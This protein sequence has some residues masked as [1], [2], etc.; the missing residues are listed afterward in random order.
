VGTVARTARIKLTG[1]STDGVDAYSSLEDQVALTY[2]AAYHYAGA[3]D[4]KPYTHRGVPGRAGPMIMKRITETLF[5]HP[6]KGVRDKINGLVSQVLRK[7]DAA[8]CVVHPAD[9]E[10]MPTWFVADRMPP[11]LTIVALSHA[12]ADKTGT[13]VKPGPSASR[14]VETYAEHKLTPEEAGETMPPG[15]VTVRQTEPKRVLTPEERIAPLKERLEQASREHLELVEEVFRLIAAHTPIGATELKYFTGR[16]DSDSSVIVGIV[17]HLADEGRIVGRIEED[18]ERLIRG[19]GS[20]PKGKRITLWAPAPGPVAERTKLPDGVPPKRGA[21]EWAEDY[22]KELDSW[23]DKLLEE[24]AR[25]YPK[26]ANR[27]RSVGVL[28]TAAGITEEQS[29]LAIQRLISLDMVYESESGRG[30]FYLTERRRGPKKKTISP[31]VNGSPAQ[32]AERDAAAAEGHD[33]VPMPDHVPNT[34]HTMVPP[35]NLVDEIAALIGRHVD[36]GELTTLRSENARLQAENERLQ[37][38]VASLKAALAALS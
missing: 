31:Y 30:T 36:N 21:K 14:V 32:N 10:Q 1:F 38:A 33:P 23:C 7:T 27:P 37:S 12:H 26:G 15:E 22:K 24:L 4:F 9:R 29:R 34:S 19:G 2:R 8:V 35:E 3:N 6:D 5:D 13:V 25:E 17:K 11:N 16:A 28:A 18:P 20:M